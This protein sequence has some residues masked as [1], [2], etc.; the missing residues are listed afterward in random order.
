MLRTLRTTINKKLNEVIQTKQ[1][2][3]LNYM[4]EVNLINL[5]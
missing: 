4:L 2:S 3:T 1:N 5:Y